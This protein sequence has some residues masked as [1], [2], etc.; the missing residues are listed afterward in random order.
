MTGCHSS[1]NKLIAL[2]DQFFFTKRNSD[3]AWKGN[4][5]LYSDQM[6][7]ADDTNREPPAILGDGA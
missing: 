2:R 5:P 6:M 3:N 7:S 4:S 1:S